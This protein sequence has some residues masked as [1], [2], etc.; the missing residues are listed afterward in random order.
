MEKGQLVGRGS[1]S[2]V[3]AWGNS[4]VIKL[5]NRGFSLSHAEIE[6]R[7]LRIAH[8]SGVP[9][10]VVEEIIEV[11]GRYGIVLERIVGKNLYEDVRA[12]PWTLFNAAGIYAELYG[13]IHSCKTTEL[14]S[15]RE[16]L[17]HGIQNN[18]VMSRLQEEAVVKAL[19]QLPDD[20]ALC[21]RDFRTHHI[22]MSNSG[23]IIVD[24]ESALFGNSSADIAMV[25]L[26]QDME[27]SKRTFVS[28][29]VHPGQLFYRAFLSR[30]L[31]SSGAR[32]QDIVSW[33]LPVA[34]ARLH[35]AGGVEKAALL[36]VVESSLQPFMKTN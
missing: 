26:G 25:S 2:E 4:Q 1:S 23:P 34:S 12:R 30:Y 14:P 33:R 27:R 5:F 36:A 7:G 31:Q 16:D 22:L 15:Q 13:M 28:R 21:L 19:H 18:G 24:W 32:Y 17:L 10:P 35:A 11:E 6:A 20:N 29:L 3:F 9:T 8:A